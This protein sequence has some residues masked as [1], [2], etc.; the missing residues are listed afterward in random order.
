[1]TNIWI[2]I[3]A[4]T[5][6]ISP[7]PIIPPPQAFADE[8]SCQKAMRSTRATDLETYAP[9]NGTIVGVRSAC[10]GV[11]IASLLRNAPR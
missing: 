5:T 10:L 1:M 6:T 3:V 8:P 4:F 9:P 7:A 11:D 2:L